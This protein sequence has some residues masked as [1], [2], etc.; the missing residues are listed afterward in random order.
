MPQPEV[1]DPLAELFAP[2][3]TALAYATLAIVALALLCLVWFFSYSGRLRSSLWVLGG[4]AFAYGIL[5]F[6]L[7]S[8]LRSTAAVAVSA[9]VFCLVLSW[10]APDVIDFPRWWSLLAIVASVA[11][12]LVFFWPSSLI[13]AKWI[14]V[15]MLISG[16]IAGALAGPIAYRIQSGKRA[17]SRREAESQRVLTLRKA[18]ERARLDAIEMRKQEMKQRRAEE[19]RAQREEEDR[20][21]QAQRDEEERLRKVQRDEREQA[22]RLAIEKQK[23][24][25]RKESAACS[26]ASGQDANLT[27]DQ[28]VERQHEILS[29]VYAGTGGQVDTQTID[30]MS[31]VDRTGYT[32]GQV[33]NSLL[34]LQ[35]IGHI[36]VESVH[37]AEKWTD[38]RVRLTEGGARLIDDSHRT[39]RSRTPN[40][41]GDSGHDPATHE[42][43]MI[44]VLFVNADP[45]NEGRLRFGTEHRDI[46][47]VLRI[48]KFRDRYL[49]RT[50]LSARIADL[51]QSILDEE[52]RIIHFSGHGSRDGAL[53]FESVSG[54]SQ[55]VPVHSLK[56]LFKVATGVDCVVMNAC[57][58]SEQAQAIAEH[59]QYVI[60]MDKAI[61]DPAAIAFATGFYQAL[62]AGKSIPEAFDFGRVHLDLLSIPESLT[63]RL[64]SR[65][66]L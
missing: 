35:G 31:V 33:M 8:M 48:A 27:A 65:E 19:F 17:E 2:L 62:G 15:P 30:L 6:G 14:G 51:T 38:K 29:C 32:S 4:T 22:L 53:C 36:S 9:T 59:V 28:L 5:H 34:A 57:Y 46:Q 21:R 52:P 20:L 54:E 12:N 47:S 23:K 50:Q 56:G 16:V 61:S 60:G 64:L 10:W 66:A 49:L 42:E 3:Y 37:N 44:V 43:N 39:T 11:V 26:A 24:L 13:E 63:P 1:Q 45:T 58:S 40:T 55:M 25:E 18:D 7:A 41:R